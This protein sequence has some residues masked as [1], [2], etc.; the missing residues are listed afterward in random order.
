MDLVA[1]MLV[2][3]LAKD[4]GDTV[5]AQL[6]RPPMRRRLSAGDSANGRR[7]FADRLMNRFVEYPRLARQ[8]QAQFDVFHVVDHSYAQLVH[9]L[10]PERTLV[11]CHDLDTFRCVLEPDVERRSRPF[12]LMTQ[13]ILSGLRRAG[14]IAC[15]TEATRDGLVARVG[16]DASR[17]TV[18]HNGPHPTC[19][20]HPETT[21]DAQAA[22]LLGRH[23][24]LDILHVGSTIARKGIDTLLQVFAGV[25]RAPSRC[26]TRPRWR[27]LYRAA[28]RPGAGVGGRGGDRGPPVPRSLHVGSGVPAL[29]RPLAALRARRLWIARPRGAGVRDAGDRQRHRRR[30]RGRR[31]GRSCAARPTMWSAGLRPSSKRLRSER[32]N[33][34]GGQS[35]RP[36][37]WRGPPCSA[38]PATQ[39]RCGRFTRASQQGRRVDEAPRASC[40]SASSIRRSAAA[41]SRCSHRCA[42]R[43]ATGSTT[44]CLPSASSRQDRPGDALTAFR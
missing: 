36:R 30:A 39:R 28:T 21:A 22:R 35:A 12:R 40:T 29:R 34:G 23:G 7:F 10:P 31:C 20:P 13:R 14:H 18:V 1:E 9:A 17:T 42:R 32:T 2:Q 15:D 37:A 24:G 3:H 6:V 19:T 11:T 16:I 43:P 27:T 41:W 25:R 5:S 4:H 44:K 26:E 38:G 33:P 8:L